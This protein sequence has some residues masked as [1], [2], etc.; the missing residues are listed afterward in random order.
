MGKR[1]RLSLIL[2]LS[3]VFGMI[4]IMTVVAGKTAP[5]KPVGYLIVSNNLCI[6]VRA[7]ARQ[8]STIPGQAPLTVMLE[9]QETV[10]T[11][12]GG[13]LLLAV[14]LDELDAAIR[15]YRLEKLNLIE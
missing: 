13:Y 14:P 7:P 9:D 12:Q 11:I 5:K 10:V 4:C 2:L 8:I 15:K 1:I 6:V 3:C